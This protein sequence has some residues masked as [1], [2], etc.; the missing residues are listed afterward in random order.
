MGRT[1]NQVTLIGNLGRDPELKRLSN[2]GVLSSLS[3]A[4]NHVYKDKEG[5]KQTGTDWF[6]CDVW[7][8]SAEVIEQYVKKGHK[9]AVS[10]HLKTNS[11]ENKHGHQVNEVRIIVT[12]FLLLPQRGDTVQLGG[13]TFTQPTEPKEPIPESVKEGRDNDLPF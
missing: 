11:Y 13:Q 5:D 7:G 9:L 12:D 10:G 4:V 6:Y 2:G 8:K 3:L 1:N